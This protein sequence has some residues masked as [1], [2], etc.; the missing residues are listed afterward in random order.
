MKL[1]SMEELRTVKG[2]SYSRPHIFRLMKVRAF[3]R[4]IKLGE[5]RN[6]WLEEE[7]DKWIGGKI[8]ERGG[9]S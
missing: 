3:P 7:I 1:L 2:I 6:A 8:K 4:P 9:Q 5:N